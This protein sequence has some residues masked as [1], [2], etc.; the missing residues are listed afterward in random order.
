MS[1]IPWK[2]FRDFDQFF[3]NWEEPERFL[4]IIPS[5][6]TPRMDIYEDGSG[7]LIAEAELPG[8]DPK[9]INIEIKDNILK[10]EAKTEK[11]EEEKRKGYY[12]KEM[13]ENYYK[14]VIPLPTEVKGEKAEASYKDGILKIIIPQVEP[15]KE[16]KKGIKVKVKSG[17]K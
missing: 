9:D 10:L 6:K 8:I 7:N 14:R 15:K 5:T 16:E 12:R 17:K 4:S 1:L 2:P 13:S 3:E 11:K